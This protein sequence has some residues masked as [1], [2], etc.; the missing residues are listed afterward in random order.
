[1]FA[2]S[3]PRDTQFDRRC[4]FGDSKVDFRQRRRSVAATADQ[5]RRLAARRSH[6][7]YDHSNRLARRVRVLSRRMM[8]LKLLPERTDLID[9]RC[10]SQRSEQPTASDFD[11]SHL[12][13]NFESQTRG[14]VIVNQSLL[15][16]RKFPAIRQNGFCDCSMLEVCHRLRKRKQPAGVQVTS[17]GCL[18]FGTL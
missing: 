7:F 3:W 10:H 11:L 13:C 16:V 14:G 8:F 6:H 9:R 15:L 1:L 4:V 12:L 5:L 17:A 18:F 2:T